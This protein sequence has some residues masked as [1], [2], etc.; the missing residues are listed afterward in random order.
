MLQILGNTEYLLDAMDACSCHWGHGIGH[1]TMFVLMMSTSCDGVLPIS[2]TLCDAISVILANSVILAI[3]NRIICYTYMITPVYPQR[4]G[5]DA[6]QPSIV[7]ADLKG[8]EQ[9]SSQGKRLQSAGM[10]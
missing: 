4:P 7:T 9:N 1:V 2:L 8:S 3:V 10:D 6:S 5:P